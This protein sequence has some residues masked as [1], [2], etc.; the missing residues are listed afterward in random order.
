MAAPATPD[1]VPE[2]VHASCVALAGRGL[3]I[4][5]ASGRGKST[6]ALQLMALGAELVADDRVAL[7]RSG[8]VVI[9]SAP[10][11]IAGLIEARGLGLLH[12]EPAAPTPVFALLDLDRVEADRLPQAR[13][14]DLLGQSVTLL[15]RVDAPHFA[16]ALVQLLRTGQRT[17]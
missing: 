4:T 11:A 16:A 1:A 2:I 3:L 13:K 6:L 5:G 9:A 8:D 17:L 15:F 7:S 14:I 10:A 12:A